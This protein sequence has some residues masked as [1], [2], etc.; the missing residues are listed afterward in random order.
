MRILRSASLLVAATVALVATAS[1]ALAH[2]CINESKKSGAG[3]VADLYVTFIVENGML[4]DEIDDVQNMKANPKNMPRGAFFTA[5]FA[6]VIDGGEPVSMGVYDIFVHVDLPLKPRL[7]GPGD[8]LC[9]GTGLG[10]T[11]ACLD[12]QIAALLGA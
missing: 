8:S 9:D 6:A 10:D 4:V 3:S 1:P 2:T 12:A 5:H 11:G 7:G